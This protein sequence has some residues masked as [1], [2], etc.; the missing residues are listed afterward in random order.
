MERGE[1]RNKK[2]GKK[3]RKKLFPYKC[4]GKHRVNENKTERRKK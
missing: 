1:Q 2:I 4:G 3:K